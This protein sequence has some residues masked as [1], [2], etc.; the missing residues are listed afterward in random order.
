MP[1]RIYGSLRGP[2]GVNV[3]SYIT[4]ECG[5]R[6]YVERNKTYDT[7]KNPASLYYAQDDRYLTGDEPRSRGRRHLG[8]RRDA[9]HHGERPE[10]ERLFVSLPGRRQGGAHVGRR[11]RPGAEGSTATRRRTWS[12]PTA[13]ADAQV[14]RIMD[15]LE[16]SGD[17][18]NTLVVLTADHGSVA[19]APGHFHGKYD[20]ELNYGFYNWYYGDVEN[21]PANYN[22]PQPALQELVDT[23][24][25]GLSYSDSSINVWLLD[26]SPAEK[27]PRPPGSWRTCPTSPPC[28]AATA[29]TSPWSPR[30]AGT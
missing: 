13:T 28:G 1:G 9:R 29:T 20:P 5:T 2:T 7:Y 3:P 6:Y 11:Q 18:D 4:G 8:D 19:A 10:L 27:S 21:D 14:G 17:L 25:L 12:S 15:A 26:Q 24:N 16:E 30:S 23:D 22:R